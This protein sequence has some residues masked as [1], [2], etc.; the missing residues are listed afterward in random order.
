MSE[1]RK[2]ALVRRPPSALENAEPGA[3]RILSGMVADTL[4]LARDAAVRPVD[5]DDIVRAA[6]RLRRSKGKGM[7]EENIRAFALLHRAAKAGHSEAQFLVFLCYSS[8]D[9]IQMDKVHAMEWLRKSANA[10]F[11][12]ALHFLGSEYEAGTYF[13]KDEEEAI[14]AYKKADA[15]GDRVACITLASIYEKRKEY[16]E[17]FEWTKEA[18]NSASL[19][20]Y[21]LLSR[22]TKKG[23]VFRKAMLKLPSGAEEL[24]N[25]A[26]KFTNVRLVA[27]MNRATALR[28]TM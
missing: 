25:E 23:K 24:P 22:L 12:M 14:K 7:T 16:A 3:R 4:A 15:K 21:L 5:L 28:K 9:G 26:T 18:L 13:A 11:A 27:S 6:K 1:E 2:F 19:S 8:S 10:G 20:L 17:A